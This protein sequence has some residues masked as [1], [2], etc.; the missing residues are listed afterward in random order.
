MQPFRGTLTDQDGGTPVAVEGSIE[1]SGAPHG[2][3][4]FPDADAVMQGMLD[5]KTFHLQTDGGD[6]IE[7]RLDSVS[8]GARSG[9]SRAEFSG[10]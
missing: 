6:T 10:V 2:E 8:A 5:G 7:I 3:F 9:F 4:E 1:P